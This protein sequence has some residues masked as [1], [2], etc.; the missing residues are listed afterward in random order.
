MPANRR[1]AADRL[2]REM[3]SM[4]GG[5]IQ[6]PGIEYADSI[7]DAVRSADLIV[8]FVPDELE[9][10][11]E[12]F[13]LLDRMAPPH[14]I[15]ATPTTALS[16]ADLASCTYR[17]GLCIALELE[18]SSLRSAEL[19]D[20]VTIVQ[21]EQTRPEALAA[22]RAFWRA[23]GRGIAVRTAPALPGAGA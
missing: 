4:N 21:T 14:S 17:P 5:M 12:I 19:P 9:S 15:F 6:T 2:N 3:A 18:A 13:S 20:P 8:D 11:L 7:E 10:K 1:A 23:L 16:I 22:V